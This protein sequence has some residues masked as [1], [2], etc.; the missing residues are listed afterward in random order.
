MRQYLH[1]NP[2]TISIFFRWLGAI[3]FFALIWD[4]VT[5]LFGRQIVPEF[6]T[7][8]YETADILP[9]FWIALIGASP[10]LEELFFRGFLFEGIRYSRLG[11]LG[12]VI[13][14]SIIWATMHIQYGA[15]EIISIW[16]LGLL[17]GF[18]KLKTQSIYTTIGMHSLANLWAT[19]E[20][21]VYLKIR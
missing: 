3:A 18:A 1:F 17:L 5:L 20:V 19:I 11:P 15:Y 12:A 16:L 13:L 14:T 6:M 7:Q 9:L 4:G 8:A 21:A 2:I 10:L